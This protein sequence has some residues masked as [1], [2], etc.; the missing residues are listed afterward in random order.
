MNEKEP[1]ID[2]WDCIGTDGIKCPFCG[3]EFYPDA[4]Y[5]DELVECDACSKTF[6]VSAHYSVTY[7]THKPDW[8][9]EWRRENRRVLM[10]TGRYK[11]MAQ[12]MG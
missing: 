3:Y 1:D 4:D 7:S 5:D 11:D 2:E 12:L 10:E 8:L 6:R 9:Q